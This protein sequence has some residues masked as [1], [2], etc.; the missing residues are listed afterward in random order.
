MFIRMLLATG[1]VA[2]SAVAAPGDVLWRSPVGCHH[3]GPGCWVPHFSGTDGTP[4]V[5]RD[6]G[7]VVVGSYDGRV[8]A[9]DFDDGA[10]RWN[11]S[12]DMGVG[13]GT[14]M[15]VGDCYVVCGLLEVR[16]LDFASGAA[17]WSARPGG[18]IGSCG[19]FDGTHVYVGTLRKE[20]WAL[21]GANGSVAWRYEAGGEL[22]AT[23]GPRAVDGSSL[24]CLGVG[25]AADVEENCSATVDCVRRATGAAVWRQRTGIQIQSTP[26]VSGA[27]LFVGDYDGCLYAFALEDGAALWKSCTDGRLEASPTAVAAG[28]AP[29]V[30]VGS[31]DGFVYCFRAADGERLWAFKAG[32]AVTT[33]TQG[34][35][36]STA[37]YDARANVV[38]VGGPD[39]FF[40]LD[41]DSGAAK[42]NHTVGKLVGSS[43]VLAEDRVFVGAEDGYLYAF[44]R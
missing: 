29:A 40:A 16:C 43:P 17:A 6:G 8:Y 26:V 22:W 31:G 10:Q 33:F 14:P 11:A 7:T 34:G 36:G 32:R 25:G 35:V 2:A 23:H 21:H 13:E 20:L 18:Q 3:W 9:V 44:A 42:W 37:A 12:V 15:V 4:V 28:G 5:S 38:Y 39:A 41:A 30:V 1:L 19:G 24:L 27:S